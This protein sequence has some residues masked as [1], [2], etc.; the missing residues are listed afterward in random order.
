LRILDEWE[1]RS[2]ENYVGAFDIAVIYVGLNDKDSAMLWLE[3]AY[4]ER[5]M[6][7]ELMTEPAFDGLRADPR[8][9]ELES[10]IGLTSR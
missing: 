10:R 5:I 3:K 6:R 1:A 9:I 2:R 7:L 4:G 8:F